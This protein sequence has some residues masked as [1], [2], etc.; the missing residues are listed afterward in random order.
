MTRLFSLSKFLEHIREYIFKT[1]IRI[2][3]LFIARTSA[4]LL[5]SKA[6]KLASR[7]VNFAPSEALGQAG[8][9]HTSDQSYCP[10]E[11]NIIQLMHSF[12]VNIR[13]CQPSVMSTS[14]LTLESDVHRGEANI[15]F[16]IYIFLAV[17]QQ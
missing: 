2:S 5:S 14:A 8:H 11:E 17:G 9:S 16:P 3:S 15:S 7:N 1:W 13:I 4:I 12:E 6:T 10:H